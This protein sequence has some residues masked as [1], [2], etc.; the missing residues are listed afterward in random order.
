MLKVGTRGRGL[1]KA[2]TLEEAEEMRERGYTVINCKC[3]KG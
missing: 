3:R 2:L 1:V